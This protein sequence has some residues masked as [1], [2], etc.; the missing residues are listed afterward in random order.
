MAD[1]ARTRLL[2]FSF[3]WYQSLAQEIR[4]TWQ[5]FGLMIDTHTADGLKVAREHAVVEQHADGD[6][7]EPEQHVAERLDVVLDLVAVLGLGDQHAG[8][9]GSGADPLLPAG[10]LLTGPFRG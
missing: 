5:R 2:S 6:E 10:L 8:Q 4:D 3:I 7:E 1:P 9:E